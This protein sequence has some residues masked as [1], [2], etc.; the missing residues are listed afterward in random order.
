MPVRAQQTTGSAARRSVPG[1]FLAVGAAGLVAATVGG[2]LALGLVTFAILAARPPAHRP[3]A[4]S[5]PAAAPATPAPPEPTS[6]SGRKWALPAK[7]SRCPHAQWPHLLLF[8][9]RRNT[10]LMRHHSLRAYG[11]SVE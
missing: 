5:C 11:V 7:R 9:G 3:V 2:H 8:T 6:F 10:P 4:L 1:V